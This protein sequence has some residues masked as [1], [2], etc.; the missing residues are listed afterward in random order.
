MS[1]Q[2]FVEAV[3]RGGEYDTRDILVDRKSGIAHQRITELGQ[4]FPVEA[5]N[6]L[7][8]PLYVA[9]HAIAATVPVPSISST[10]EEIIKCIRPGLPFIIWEYGA[11]AHRFHTFA[12]AR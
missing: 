6:A 4:L 10:H 7:S 2:Y 8:N 3:F 1:A 11:W 5:L 12:Q 9:I